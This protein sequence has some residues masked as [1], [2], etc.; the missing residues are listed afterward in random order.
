MDSINAT[1]ALVKRSDA[2]VAAAKPRA[3]FSSSPRLPG[4]RRTAT[5]KPARK[6]R[7]EFAQGR[8]ED[9][10]IISRQVLSDY[11]AAREA[12]GDD[13]ISKFIS[14]HYRVKNAPRAARRSNPFRRG[15]EASVAVDRTSPE[16]IRK[17]G[18]KESIVSG[19][20][21]LNPPTKV[22]TVSVL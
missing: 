15:N 6:A 5:G 7:G 17:R 20:F 2:T 16:E 11:V 13:A 3:I 10:L 21:I 9:E 19:I 14:T 8:L 18:R 12:K 1:A 4:E 22:S